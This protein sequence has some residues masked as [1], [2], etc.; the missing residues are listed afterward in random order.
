MCKVE[1]TCNTCGVTFKADNRKVNR[2]NAKYCSL[3][4]AGKAPKSRQF[5]HI[6]AHCGTSFVS[7]NSSSKYCSNFCKQKNYRLKQRVEGTNMKVLY[8]IFKDVPCEICGWEETTRDLH[9]IEEVSKGGKNEVE[10]LISVCPNHHR[11]IHKNLIS[12]DEL[13]SIVK[14]RTISSPS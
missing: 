8:S 13:L 6:C 12:K 7:A 11:M 4:C 14:S 3:S 5:S 2:R 9:H 10:N 1:K